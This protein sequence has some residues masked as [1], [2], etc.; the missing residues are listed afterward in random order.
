MYSRAEPWNF[1]LIGQKILAQ[2]ADHLIWSKWLLILISY[3]SNISNKNGH[4]VDPSGHIAT[5][6]WVLVQKEE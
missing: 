3:Y 6:F 1:C 2:L 4:P 5:F